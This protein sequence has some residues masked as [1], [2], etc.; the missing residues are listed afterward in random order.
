MIF[1]G[2]MHEILVCIIFIKHDEKAK[3]S[4][5]NEGVYWIFCFYFSLVKLIKIFL[6]SFLGSWIFF[7]IFVWDINYLLLL[8]RQRKIFEARSKKYFL[9]GRQYIADLATSIM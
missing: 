3:T 4:R 6:F 7:V 2:F 8:F 9:F 5:I 1:P